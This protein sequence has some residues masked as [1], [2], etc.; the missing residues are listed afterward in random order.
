L[1]VISVVTL[2]RCVVAF[3]TPVAQDEAYYY[4]W[5]RALSWGYF[6]HPPGVAVLGLGTLLAQGSPFVARLGTLIAS[7]LT[8]LALWRLYRACGIR[9]EPL[10]SLSLLLVAASLPGLVSGVI[11]TPDTV[12]AL[13]WVLA[14]NESLAALSGQRYRW[15][16][17]GLATG[18]GL[19]GKYTML[20]IGPV[21][22]IALLAVDRRGLRTPWPYL[23][24][25]AALL[26]FSPNLIWNA[27]HDWLAIRFQIGHGFSTD[28]GPLILAADELL[29][30]ATI[31]SGEHAKE[32]ALRPAERLASLGRFL[33]VQALFWGIP[34]LAFAAA[35]FKGRRLRRSLRSLAETLSPQAKALLTAAALV[36]LL[37]FGLIAL[38]SPV[39]P[40][41]A[42]LYIIGAAPLL[43]ALT[44]P[45]ALWVSVAAAAN[46]FL[47]SLYAAHAATA[48]LPLPHAA[49]RVLRETHGYASLADHLRSVS[50]PI[51]VDR[52]QTAA[53]LNFYGTGRQVTQWP[54]L[55]RP[56]EYGRGHIASMPDSSVLRKSGFVLVAWK[57]AIPDIPGFSI[58]EASTIF[59]CR[60]QPLHVVPKIGWPDDSPCGE[61]WIH[62]WRVLRYSP[63]DELPAKSQDLNQR[64]T[65]RLNLSVAPPRLSRHRHV[66]RCI[67]SGLNAQRAEAVSRFR[68]P[69][70]VE[71][72]L[73]LSSCAQSHPVPCGSQSLP[74]AY[75]G[76]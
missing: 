43:A 40:N 15:L 7:T 5:A 35:L 36:P 17:A 69:D 76:C 11:T 10:L 1:L 65:L 23:G 44:R 33:M 45:L 42:A 22:L 31:E 59:D 51:F 63:D 53:M 14:L 57:Y 67:C 16:S 68:G 74:V 2:W 28:T 47:L 54:G 52:Y 61:E 9:N 34:L 72:L 13:F 8:L 19:L 24:G 49:D 25:V 46:M 32:V 12:L 41:W 6:D 39:E 55:T 3:A 29:G 56:S 37:L 50:G 26:V 21:F 60:G 75:W 64:L 20:M 30:V 71:R 70:R 38:G 66:V 58:A 27:Q 62:I 4:E 73:V 48:T 18:L